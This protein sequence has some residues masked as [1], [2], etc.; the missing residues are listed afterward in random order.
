MSPTERRLAMLP[1]RYPNAQVTQ[2]HHHL[3]TDRLDPYALH[4]A[5]FAGYTG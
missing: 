2:S 5:V 1:W 3:C 4:V